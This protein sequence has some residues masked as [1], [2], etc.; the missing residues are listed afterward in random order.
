MAY[1]SN[2]SSL[3]NLISLDALPEWS[4][5][6]PQEVENVG[7]FDSSGAFMPVKV[8][9]IFTVFCPVLVQLF[10]CRASAFEWLVG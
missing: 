9:D 1:S 3:V 10:V 7:T 8:T 5:A 4:T 6:N 2:F